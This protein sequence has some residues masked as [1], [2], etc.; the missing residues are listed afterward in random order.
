MNIDRYHRQTL[1]PQI[2]TQGQERL[3]AASIVLIGCGALGTVIADQLVRAGIGRLRIID[4]DIVEVTNLQRQVLFLPQLVLLL[5]PLVLFLLQLVL[6]ELPIQAVFH[7]A[8]ALGISSRAS[9]SVN[10]TCR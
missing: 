7:A 9:D 2:G 3:R 5:Q 4:R 10:K 8:I 1:L 6:L